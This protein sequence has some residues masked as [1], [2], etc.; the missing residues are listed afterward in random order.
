MIL[1]PCPPLDNA[2]NGMINCLLLGDDNFTSYED[3][4]IITCNTGDELTAAGNDTR[5]CQSDGSW[6]TTDSLL[7][8]QGLQLCVLRTT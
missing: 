7:C 8:I 4:C 3:I 1:V 2:S 6:S 5:I